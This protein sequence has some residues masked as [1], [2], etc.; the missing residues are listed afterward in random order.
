MP[1]LFRPDWKKVFDTRSNSEERSPNYQDRV[2]L[3]EG[4]ISAKNVT[5]VG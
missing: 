4:V 3:P 1:A 5:S 2:T